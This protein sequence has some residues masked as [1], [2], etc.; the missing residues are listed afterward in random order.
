MT[1]RR[2]VVM[3]SDAQNRHTERW[4]RWLNDQPGWRVTLLSDRP[5]VSGFNYEGIP[6]RNPRWSLWQNIMAFKV[7]GGIYANNRHKW[8]VYRPLIEEAKPDVLHAMEALAYGPTLHHFPGTPRVLTPW[9][10]DVESLQGRDRERAELVLQGMLAA[11]RIATNAPGLEGHWSDLSGLTRERFD[12]FPWGVDS[13]IFHAAAPL[14][15]ELQQRLGLGPTTRLFLSPRLAKPYYRVDVILAGWRECLAARPELRE[16]ARLVILRAGAD[17]ASWSVLMAQAAELS[18]VAMVD[19]RL[20]P[21]QMAGLYARTEGTLM[22]PETD[23]LS[24]SLLESIA[25]GSFPI[26]PDQPCNG[27]ALADRELIADKACGRL[28]PVV[29]PLSIGTALLECAGLPSGRRAEIRQHNTEVA[30]R[31]FDWHQCAGRMLGI[32]EELLHGR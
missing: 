6:V 27:E 30:R 12:L 17:D 32:Y 13:G 21:S 29:T 26:V 20:N 9:G 31:R 23:L 1:T 3:L 8:R 16:S 2:H 5:A 11:D 28:V 22:L 14:D 10:P 24:M 18:A 25:C 7:D 4:C 19:E 15:S